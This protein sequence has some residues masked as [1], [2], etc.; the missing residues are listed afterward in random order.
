MIKSDDISII[1]QGAINKT[2]TLKCLRSIR[3]FLPNAEVILST[4]EGSDVRDLNGLYNILVLNKDPG[5]GYY[6][7]HD[8]EVKLNNL[9]RQ[10][11]STQEGLKRATKKY[12]MK[13][14]SDII[15]TNN[16]FL[17]FFEKYQVRSEEYKLFERKILTSAV[18]SRFYFNDYYGLNKLPKINL[19]FH[20]SDWWFFGLKLDLEKYFNVPLVKEPEFSN[21]YKLEENKNKFN[22]YIYIDESYVQFAAEQYIAVK[23][24]ENNFADIHHEHAGDLN[25][26]IIAQSRKCLINNFIFLEFKDSGIYFNKYKISKFVRFSPV[27]MDLYNKYRQEYEYKKYCEKI[28]HISKTTK[29]I[30]ENEKFQKDYMFLLIHFKKVLGH[31]LKPIDIIKEMFITLYLV[32]LFIL[33]YNKHILFIMYN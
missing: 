11:F 8:K 26:K 1:V 2:E 31:S 3:K 22:P 5:F 18:C 17:K 16:T 19:A 21:Y 9:N 24:F 33:K 32:F 10:L 28:F 23:C 4:W 7:K 25:S 15:F 13:I 29:F 30:I 12:A 14:R 20:V 27:Y 6:Y